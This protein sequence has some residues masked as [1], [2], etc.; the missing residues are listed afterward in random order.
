MTHHPDFPPHL[1]Y[2]R[3]RR[4]VPWLR[5]GFLL[6]VGAF[7]IGFLVS[8]D[9]RERTREVA[10]KAAT[11]ASEVQAATEPPRRHGVAADDFTPERDAFAGASGANVR[12]YPLPHA[13]LLLELPARAP[14]SINGRLNVQG[15]WWFRV[16]LPDQRIGFV[17]Q[18][19]IAWGRAPA[20]AAAPAQ[21]ANF[22][23]VEPA[24]EARAG[25][26][27]AK[28]RTSPSRT[29]HMIVRIARGAEV[30]IT[31]KRRIGAHWWY[32]V[33][34]EDGREGFARGDVLTG[35]DGGAL[36]V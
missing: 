9:V 23:T 29:A 1:Y 17:H 30:S 5:G 32:R 31:G 8:D 24:A 20:P 25:R 26:A 27:G 28:I 14:L 33:Q 13:D 2:A 36:R 16:V 12:D 3:P 35:P 11:W 19:A 4:R 21:V 18:N 15:E 6:I 34:L 10:A 22:T 7:V